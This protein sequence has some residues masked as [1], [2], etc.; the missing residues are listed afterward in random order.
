[1]IKNILALVLFFNFCSVLAGEQIDVTKYGAIPNDGIDDTKALRKAVKDVCKTPGST[2]YIPEG[3]Y[4]LKDNDAVKLEEDVIKGKFGE[5]PEK[6]IYTPYYKYSKGL[7]FTGAKNVTISADKVTIMCEGWM[8]P[9]SLDLCENVTIKGLTIDYKRKPFVSGDIINVSSDYFDVQF[10]DEKVVTESMPLTR[11][12]IWNK[13]ENRLYPEPIYFPKRE[14][15]GGN[16]VRFHHSIPNNLLG[17]NT[18]VLNSFHFRPAIL[19]YRSKVT[20]LEDVTIH[21]QAGMGIVGFDSKDIFIKRLSISPSK[22]YYQSTNTDATHFACCSGLLHFQGC[23]FQG[24]GD[25]ATNVHGYYQTILESVDNHAIIEVQA[26]TYTHA[27][28][29]DV[30]RIGDIMELVEKKT[31]KPVKNFTVIGVKHSIPDTKV[32]VKLSEKLPDNISDYYLMNISKLPKLVFENSVINSHLARGI[33]VKTRNVEIRNNVFRN[34]TG[35]AI[36]IGAE[37]NWHEGTHSENVLVKDNVIYGCGSGAGSQAGA[38][39]LA[40]KIEADDT[41]NTCLHKNLVIENN[42]ISGENNPCGIYVGN[43]KN[44]ILKNNKIV[45]CKE[46]ILLHSVSELN[47]Q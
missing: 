38:S 45:S 7:D 16:K 37:S 28:V 42:L 30:P 11:L 20:S 21:S 34:G 6:I 5:N 22:G 36:H 27:Q 18:T 4:I 32:E 47:I 10:G 3:I 23:Y 9:I 29:A 26:V 33:L 19:I 44:I 43:A 17:S 25:D 35:T 41:N 12:T 39:G 8:E 2:L 31:L 24:Q 14:L 13:S 15:L 46:E 40:V 1:M